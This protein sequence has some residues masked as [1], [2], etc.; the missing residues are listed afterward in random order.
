MDRDEYIDIDTSGEGLWPNKV[1]SGLIQIPR[2]RFGMTWDHSGLNFWQRLRLAV[3]YTLWP[4][5]V[6]L[7]PK[8]NW[9]LYYTVKPSQDGQGA[10]AVR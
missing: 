8:G 2:S 1:E 4:L 10:E 7:K 5:A 6:V 3:I 9:L